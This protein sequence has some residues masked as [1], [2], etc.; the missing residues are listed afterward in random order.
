MRSAI[1]VLVVVG[2]ILGI[3]SSSRTPVV[4]PFCWVLFALVALAQVGFR[5]R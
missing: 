5:R 4:R 1:A 2:A 3:I